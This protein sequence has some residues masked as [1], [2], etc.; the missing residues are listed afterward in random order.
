MKKSE[1]AHKNQVLEMLSKQKILSVSNIESYKTI[2][3]CYLK[4]IGLKYLKGKTATSCRSFAFNRVL[5]NGECFSLQT[6]IL[7]PNLDSVC[8]FSPVP[9]RF[10][11]PTS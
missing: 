1:K 4:K 10:I 6:N 2:V 11:T 8:T 5:I 9:F 7:I 3:V